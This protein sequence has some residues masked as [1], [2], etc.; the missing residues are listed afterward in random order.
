MSRVYL[1]ID[2]GATKTAGALVDAS[3]V[4]MVEYGTMGSAIV[5]KPSP[6]ACEV[7]ASVVAELCGSAGVRREEI[8]RVGIGLNGVDFADEMPIQ[9]AELVRVLGFAT[10]RLTLVN[11]GIAALWG[12]TPTRAAVIVQH[13]TAFTAAWRSDYG[14]EQLFDHLDA[15]RF[16]DLRTET[17]TL[18][19]RMIDGRAEPTSLQRKVL[20]CL[21]GVSEETYAEIVY[22]RR[23]TPEQRDRLLPAVFAA[24]GEGDHA[25]K[26]L[27][28]RAI[29]DYACTASAMVRKTGS[30]APDVVFG[31]GRFVSAPE[32]FVGR[33]S[34]AVRRGCPGAKV[35]RPERSPA[36][37]AAI[38]AA[39]ADGV[40]PGVLFG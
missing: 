6:E 12:A 26:V 33:L 34:D 11:D 37:G 16:L 38:M 36:T 18:V 23:I 9:H 2:G 7:L 27:V 19:A 40:K 35:K 14:R 25:A 1:G 15:G 3:G 29:S 17:L 21:D 10:E 4:V 5:G 30:D 24:A 8:A 22:R 31:G 13:G 20:D 39:F 32:W 28:D